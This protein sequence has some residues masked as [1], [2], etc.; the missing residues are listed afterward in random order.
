MENLHCPSS[1]DEHSRRTTFEERKCDMAVQPK[2]CPEGLAM[3]FAE[4]VFQCVEDSRRFW[5]SG[6]TKDAEASKKL[7]ENRERRQEKSD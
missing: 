6:R 1:D 2:K 4:A 5:H 7:A 3:S